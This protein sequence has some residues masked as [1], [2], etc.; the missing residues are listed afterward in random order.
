MPTTPEKQRAPLPGAQ[1]ME[2]MYLNNTTLRKF[3]FSKSTPANAANSAKVPANKG[4]SSA[5]PLLRFAKVDKKKENISNFSKSLASQELFEI[6]SLSNISS[7]SSPKGINSKKPLREQI[8]TLWKKAWAL[9]DWM[10]DSQSG[11]PWEER[12]AKIPELSKMTD[13]IDRLIAQQKCS[14]ASSPVLKIEPVKVVEPDTC[15]AQCKNT[16][17]CYGRAYFNGK[18]GPA[19]GCLPDLCGWMQT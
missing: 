11:V 17:K 15:P 8:D 18:P 1:G 10:D 5:K 13:E 9:A 12:A 7:I 3:K 19:A 14:S 16:G 4:T 2:Q 6:N